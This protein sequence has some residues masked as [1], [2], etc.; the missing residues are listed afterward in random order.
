MKF[1]LVFM[2]ALASCNGANGIFS[3][4]DVVGSDRS[5]PPKY[6]TGEKPT[7]HILVFCLDDSPTSLASCTA[8]ARAAHHR[9]Y[10]L[11]F[12]SARA[13][14]AHM[15]KHGKMPH[16]MI[17]DMV[18]DTKDTDFGISGHTLLETF[19]GFTLVAVVTAAERPA[20]FVQL[21]EDGAVFALKKTN[22]GELT[23]RVRD[24]VE[25]LAKLLAPIT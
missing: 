24:V 2:L 12:P 1:V 19:K 22:A 3:D 10:S 17:V 8:R 6:L 23:D 9:V 11:G 14:F 25:P 4:Q 18:L 16:F 13:M 15:A 20:L 5:E 21:V 7:N